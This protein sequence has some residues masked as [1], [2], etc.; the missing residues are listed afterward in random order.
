MAEKSKNVAKRD[1][2]SCWRDAGI[3]CV[4]FC[5]TNT[6]EGNCFRKQG[7]WMNFRGKDENNM[8]EENFILKQ[9]CLHV[10]Q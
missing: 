2:V 7:S 10:F 8:E 5:I 3:V 9:F 4:L 1:S 6:E